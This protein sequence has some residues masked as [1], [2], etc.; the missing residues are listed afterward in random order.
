[1]SKI[2]SYAAMQYMRNARRHVIGCFRRRYCAFTGNQLENWHASIPFPSSFTKKRRKAW[3]RKT[4]TAVADAVLQTE[5]GALEGEALKQELLLL[6]QQ[7]LVD[8]HVTRSVTAA[9][10][11]CIT[12][13]L[14]FAR[15]QVEQHRAVLPLEGC[16]GHKEWHRLLPWHGERT[17]LREVMEEGIREGQSGR[18]S[19]RCCLWVLSPLSSSLSIRRC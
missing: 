3:E 1:M 6:L 4:A 15:N 17:K 9:R 18:S 10:D 2:L 19:L 16:T 14:E 11:A 13:V 8:S 5:G 12:R 7:L